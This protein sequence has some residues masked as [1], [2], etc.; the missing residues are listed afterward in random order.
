M[1][2]NLICLLLGFILGIVAIAM[3]RRKID[4]KIYERGLKEGVEM[5]MEHLDEAREVN[6]Q[7]VEVIKNVTNRNTIH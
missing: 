7:L 6:H 4:A 5:V 1:I 3:L 2:E